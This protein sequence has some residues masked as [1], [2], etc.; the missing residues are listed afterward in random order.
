MAEMGSP[1]LWGICFGVMLG[2]VG[3]E[4]ILT[5]AFKIQVSITLDMLD[6]LKHTQNAKD[7]IRN[8]FTNTGLVG[9]LLLTV[10]FA[11]MFVDKPGV[12][13]ELSHTYIAATSYATIQGMR[14]TTESVIHVVYTEALSDADIIRYLIFRPGSVGGP[15]I[16]VAFCILGMV[17]STTIFLIGSYSVAAGVAWGA[18]GGFQIVKLILNALKSSKFSVHRS[19]Q[20]ALKWTWAEQ[21]DS[22]AP[23]EVSSKCRA[24]HIKIFKDQAI[25]AREWEKKCKAAEGIESE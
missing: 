11:M 1:S 9:A 6:N 17:V 5:Y 10:A 8:I 16:A 19:D 15:V 20:I 7:C 14:A 3:L 23:I 22:V 18:F 24:A 21:E 12:S 13:E 2:Q 4:L 25:Q